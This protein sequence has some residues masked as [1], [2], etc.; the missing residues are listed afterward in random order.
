MKLPTNIQIYLVVRENYDGNCI[1][2]VKAFQQLGKMLST[3][4][5]FNSAF[6]VLKAG[7][8]LAMTSDESD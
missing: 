6:V 7:V 5:V 8:E 3:D 1:G 4:V 2:H